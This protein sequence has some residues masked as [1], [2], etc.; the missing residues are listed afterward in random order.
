MSDPRSRI[1]RLAS[2]IERDEIAPL[3]P[4]ATRLGRRRRILAA[5]YLAQAE[6]VMDQIK[7]DDKVS[8]KRHVMLVNRAEAILQRLQEA[9]ALAARPDD[10]LD[11]ALRTLK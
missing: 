8:P 9:E 4:V 6:M 11:V 7:A 3:Y 1:R 5:R 10:P 2:R